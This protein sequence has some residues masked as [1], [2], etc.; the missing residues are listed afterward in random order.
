MFNTLKNSTGRKYKDFKNVF[1][2]IC[3]YGPLSKAQLIEISGMKLTTLNRAMSWLLES[4][5]VIAMDI[6]ESNGGR[7]PVLYG[8]NPKAGYIVGI[9]ISRTNT[10]IALMD[11]Q[12]NILQ[13]TVFAMFEDSGPDATFQKICDTLDDFYTTIEKEKVLGI[14]IGVIGPID[15]E[16]GIIIN[17]SNFSAAGWEN[18]SITKRL[19]SATG[20]KIIIEKSECAA[21]LGEYHA[22]FGR[23]YQSLAYIIA[24]VGVRLGRMMNGAIVN[25][26]KNSEGEFGHTVVEQGGALCSCGNTGCLE[27][28]ASTH[29]LLEK[30]I[31]E[32]KKGRASKALT[33]VDYD[34]SAINLDIFYRA[35]GSE[36]ELAVEIIR[37]AADYFSLAILNIIN[38]IEPEV[39]ILGGPLIKNCDLFYR[40]STQ[41]AREK[42]EKYATRHAIFSKGELQENAAV[43]GA[44][45]LV[46]EYYL[47]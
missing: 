18:V 35:V 12:H 43:I 40:L 8:A 21:V 3:S 4:G 33:M 30:F 1:K 31:G 24:G 45:N 41:G 17:P 28:Y 34:L 44:G 42:L 23:R 10:R 38:V 5:M 14:G 2:L 32:M 11:V 36:D 15:K 19:E 47:Q 20:L 25:A 39:L 27:A 9:D 26:P 13:T 29:K 46:L 37:T 7:K 16:K 6:G 22:G